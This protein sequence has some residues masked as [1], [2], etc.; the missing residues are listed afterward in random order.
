MRHQRLRCLALGV[1][2]AAAVVLGGAVQACTDILVGRDASVDG[3]V[4]TSHTCDGQYDS[5]LQIVPAAKHAPGDMAPVWEFIVNG[6]LKPLKKLGE[7]P[8]AAETGK[9]FHIAYPFMN[10][11]QL[12]IGETT[13]G[14]RKET[15]N[16]DRAIMTIEQLEVYALQR[17]ST[18]REAIQ[19]MGDLAVKYGYRESCDLGECLT[20]SDRDEVWVF[21]IFGV[22]PLWT[23]ESG[24]PGA[25]WAAR[26]VPDDHVCVVPN[27]SRIG[28][29]DPSDPDLMVSDNYLD[30][31]VELGLYD[32]ESGEPFIW[33]NVYGDAE[34]ASIG[35]RTRLWRVY[36]ALCPSRKWDMWTAAETYPFSVKPEEQVSV[37]DLIELFRDTM[38]GTQ[39]DMTNDADWFV[40][41]KDAW[42]KSPLATPQVNSTWRSLLD[43]EY[44]R[45]IARYYCSY[46]F[47]SQAR[48]W[49]PDPIGGVAWFGLDNPETSLF[50]PVYSGVNSVPE[51]WA[52]ADRSKL[53]WS[54]AW[55]SFALV[56]DL[57]NQRYQ[58]MFPELKKLRD[59]L[60]ERFYA[61]QEA[62]EKKAVELW[63]TDPEAAR[64]FL[65]EYT[66]R[67]L[68]EAHQLYRG[69]V[70]QFLFK[71]NNN[72]F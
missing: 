67:C 38:A 14:G 57:V 64:R 45:P 5:R 65:T 61:E 30:T 63:E 13:I 3:S 8:E 50:V 9:Y 2:L 32:P 44:Y 28:E 17:C 15:A 59:P 24:K 7:I 10:E 37:R 16:S 29:I 18:A 70:D 72:N 20:V 53:D 68:D 52:K 21:E 6:D 41:G 43:I 35:S 69:L 23:P 1:G 27:I 58:E 51:A 71:L 48:S 39:F 62:V 40:K 47:V 33:K 46:F 56:D 34:N 60:Q 55:W 26:R 66:G 22:G 25:V 11:R 54:S 19:L 31:A 4:I 42:V 12:I 36:S 49:L